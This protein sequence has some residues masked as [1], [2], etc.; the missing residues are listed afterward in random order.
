V[1][2]RVGQFGDLADPDQAVAEIRQQMQSGPPPGLEGV[3]RLLML[4]DRH[5]GRGMVLNFFDT[6]DEM[7]RGHEALN[8]MS[9]EGGARRTAVEMY[10]VG[11]DEQF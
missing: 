6:E 9:P 11:L 3:K 1:H 10:E 2:V 4:I 7:R 8:A 5:Q